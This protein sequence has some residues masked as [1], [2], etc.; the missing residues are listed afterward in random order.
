MKKVAACLITI[1]GLCLGIGNVY[2]AEDIVKKDPVIS[3]Q[4][5]EKK[6]FRNYS[7]QGSNSVSSFCLE[8]HVF[9]MVSGDNSNT[10]SI[11]Q[12]F[13]EKSGRVVP[14]RCN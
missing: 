3:D 1:I 2:A 8:G 9:V 6:S 12:V 14:K 5:R 13:E 4:S 7:G 11:I 10:A